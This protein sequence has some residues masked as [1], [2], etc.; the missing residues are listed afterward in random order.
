MTDLESELGFALL[1]RSTHGVVLTK[2]GEGLLGNCLDTFAALD[3]Y[4]V[5]TRN[6]KAGPHGSLHVKA[7]TEYGHSIV[8]PLI[9]EFM[10]KYP[11]LRVQLVLKAGNMNSLEDGCDVIVATRKPE[12]PG[13][14]GRDIGQIQQVICAA[15][16]YFRYHG[17]PASPL[18]LRE[19]NCLVN[20]LAAATKWA[21]RSGSKDIF[22]NV[23]GTFSSNS[24]AA[25]IR[26]ALEGVGIIRV[27]RH[28]VKKELATGKLQAL[29]R[30]I[31][32]S[33]EQLRAYFSKSRNLPAKV[34]EFVKF[35]QTSASVG[36]L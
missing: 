1:N 33:N 35:L 2:E 26:V 36:G 19:H 28:A 16:R 31:T 32:Q 5:N 21:F 15:P 10:R 20:S 6:H 11:K 4:I 22:V 17:K 8:A 23:K 9:S 18:Q 30:D 25:L 27:P 7:T 12:G 29:F 34:T 3:G 13:L 14:V 24:S